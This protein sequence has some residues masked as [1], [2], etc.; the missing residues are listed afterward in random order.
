[1]LSFQVDNTPF[2]RQGSLAGLDREAMTMATFPLEWMYQRGSHVRESDGLTRAAEGDAATARQ[3]TA[4]DAAAAFYRT[5]L[6]QVGV[7]T[8]RDLLAWLD[9][10]VTYNRARVAEGAAAQADLLRSQLERDRVAMDVTMQEADLARAR[11]MLRA[12]IGDPHLAAMRT[13]VVADEMPLALPMVRDG[14]PTD[15]SDVRAARDRLDASRAGVAMERSRIVRQLGATMGTKQT[16][17][18]TSMIAGVSLPLPLFD[19]NRGEV[20]RASAD[21]DVAAFELAAQERLASAEVVGSYEAAQLLT[22]RATQLTTGG[23]TSLLFRADDARRIALGAYREGAVP[24]LSV[25]DAA[26]TWGD[27][28][29]TFYRTLYAQHESVLALLVAQGVDL[30]SNLPASAQPRAPNR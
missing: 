9:T 24:L 26:R 23:T 8:A 10:V 15:R 11:A 1:M 29:L 5:A 30:L 6:A 12:F 2:P 27:I 16:M 20:R 28:R 13:I 4:M 18:T 14:M 25:L 7:T 22:D 19:F 21:R 17:G 3:R